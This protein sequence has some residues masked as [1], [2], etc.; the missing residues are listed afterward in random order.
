MTDSAVDRCVSLLADFVGYRTVN[1]GGDE[2]ALCA[3]VAEELQKRGPDEVIVGEVQRPGRSPGGYVFAFYGTP[4]TVINVHLDT[5]P[6]NTGWTRDPFRAEVS[7]GRLYG[8]GSSDTKG[9]MAAALVALD[10]LAA[11]GAGKPRDVGVLFSGDEEN[12]SL[13]MHS[14]LEQEPCARSIE[15]AIVC[16]P[17]ARRAGVRHRGVRTYRAHVRGQ[18]GHSSKADTMPKPMVIMS[19]LALA[20]DELGRRYLDQGPRDMRGLCMNVAAIDGGVAFNVIPDSATLTFSVRPPPGFDADVFERELHA[21]LAAAGPGIAL[22]P[23][24]V[25]EPFA[26]RDQALFETLLGAS[27][28]ELGPLDFWTE[29]ALWS[30]AGVDAVVIGP[31]DIAQAHAPDEFVTLSDLGW[32]IE[33]FTRVLGRGAA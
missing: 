29:A 33:L 1:P 22:A 30:A 28:V 17:T 6:V 31:G 13:V 10:E 12:G 9:A 25:A 19:R 5:V 32:A 3:R 24:L 23:G 18:G 14:F 7:D 8:L 11:M 21:C 26:C 15:R 2:L 16:E 4:R 20:L 27:P